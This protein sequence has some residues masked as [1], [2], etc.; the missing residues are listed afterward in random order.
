MAVLCLHTVTNLLEH[1]IQN[2]KAGLKVG[3]VPLLFISAFENSSLYKY[4]LGTIFIGSLT[5]GVIIVLQTHFFRHKIQTLG[6][7]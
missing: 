5:F 7:S 3:S 2:S 6:T 4:V 1:D